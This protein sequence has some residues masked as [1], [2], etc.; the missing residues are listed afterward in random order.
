MRKIGGFVSPF[1]GFTE[2]CY[3]ELYTNY[4]ENLTEN[5][6]VK[7]SCGQVIRKWKIISVKAPY[8]YIV[9]HVP[10]TEEDK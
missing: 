9:K 3:G 7:A 1:E 8:Y 5:E 10:I 6:I 2:G 4:P